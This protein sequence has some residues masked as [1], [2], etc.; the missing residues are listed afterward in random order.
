M[1]DLFAIIKTESASLVRGFLTIF[2]LALPFTFI[3]ALFRNGFSMHV[4]GQRLPG[5]L[6]YSAILAT[7]VILIALLNNYNKLQQK[8]RIFDLP[9][10][11]ELGFEGAVEG[12]NAII[13]E[14]STYL[15]GKVGNYSFRVD[16]I[17]P[18]QKNITVEI[19]P[20]IYIGQNQA[21][22]N[23]LVQELHLQDNLYLARILYLSEAQLYERDTV[24]KELARLS[25]ELSRMGVTPL[26][27]VTEV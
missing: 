22:L 18:K 25:D 6:L 19:A 23:R 14:L 3:P 4:I 10:F 1:K 24:R 11:T 2:L 17:H 8:K 5:S 21:L 7:G 26:E 15:I 27:A 16:I 13:K 20:M 12:Y 9:A